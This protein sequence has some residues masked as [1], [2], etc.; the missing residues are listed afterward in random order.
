MAKHEGK[1]TKRV[2]EAWAYK[3]GDAILWDGKLTGFGVKANKGGSKSY[4]ITYRNRYNTLRQYTIGKHGGKLTTE[5]CRK[6]AED[7]LADI[8]LNG[9]DP[10]E[11][12]KERRKAATVDELLDV[13]LESSKFA[14]KAESTRYVDKGRI[15]RHLRPTLG[16]IRLEKLTPDDVRRA[17]AD[18]RDGKTSVVKKSGNAR[19]R[20]N[21]RG[22]DGAARMAI[23]VFRA[24][25]NWA[26]AEGRAT[27]NP[28]THLDLA[29]DGKRDLILE[30]PEQ[31][32]ALFDALDKLETLRKIP[33]SAADA[34]RVLAF[35]GARRNEVAGLRWEWVDLEAGIFTLPP[36]SH[37]TGH[38][39]GQGK[40]IAL[41]STALAIV[42]ARQG[43]KS[44]H[45]FP[46]SR[47]D[48]HVSLTSKL[49]KEIRKE[50]GLPEGL[51]NHSLRHSLGTMMAMQ[52]AQAAEIMATLGHS[53]LSTAQR[54][55]HASRDAKAALAEKYTGTISGAMKKGKAKV[56]KIKRKAS[57]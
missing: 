32:A 42:K 1:I 23:R 14:E 25:L 6:K 18:I 38:K 44:E 33:D 57:K 5:E 30:T 9:A 11:D 48:T 50:S 43:N 34:I 27:D 53:Q 52:G 13:Y 46:S 26:I 28:A 21:V 17:Y 3:P 49:W 15:E 56:V 16:Q 4:I 29:G 41:N 12:R 39:S 51:S 55:I 10:L 36:K 24:I 2:A 8:R 47:G 20:V 54:Y 31:Y 35:T 45:V 19:G 22:G 37:K 40:T 7:L